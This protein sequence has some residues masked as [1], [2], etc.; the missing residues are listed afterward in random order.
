MAASVAG[1]FNIAARGSMIQSTCTLAEIDRS[2]AAKKYK[3]NK[4][5][6][7]NWQLYTK[8]N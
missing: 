6:Q 8:L 3:V 7:T 4:A 5:K 2:A 1:S